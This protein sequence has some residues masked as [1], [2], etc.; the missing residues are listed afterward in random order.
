MTE[1]ARGLRPC[2]LVYPRWW[3]DEGG[4]HRT[5]FPPAQNGRPTPGLVLDVFLIE[6]IDRVVV[7]VLSPIGRLMTLLVEDIIKHRTTDEADDE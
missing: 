7:L 3:W 1:A 4:Y 6:E 2:D 5:D